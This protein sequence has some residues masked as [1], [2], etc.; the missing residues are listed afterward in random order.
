MRSGWQSILGVV[1]SLISFSGETSP[2]Q[3]Q[4][5]IP[6]VQ[7]EAGSQN[8]TGTMEVSGS[9]QDLSSLQFVLTAATQ[10]V[11]VDRISVGFGRTDRDE[12]LGN[13]AFLDTLQARLI[14][15]ANA[16][17]VLDAG[18]A[19][20]D[21]RTLEELED[22]DSVTFT[23]SPALSLA[24]GV[25]TTLL[26]VIDINGPNS[27]S[28]HALPASSRWARSGWYT[29][30]GLFVLP[31]VGLVLGATQSRGR[32]S[33]WPRRYLPWLFLVMLWSMI[34]PGCSG[35]DDGD[36]LSFIVNLPSNG[37]TSQ[38]LRLGPADAI[39]GITVRLTN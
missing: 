11:R 31:L 25:P 38:T 24:A 9:I 5:G 14:D 20:L 35:D 16:N 30:S 39:S 8:P 7:I 4:G 1:I 29:T 13:M 26:T 3:A 18:E 34:L 32:R 33:R 10:T 27:Q 12:T 37:V 6:V 19:V 36:E 22:P 23:L 15:D 17:G 28:A 21:S 2:V